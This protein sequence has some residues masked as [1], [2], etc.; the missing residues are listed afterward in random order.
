MTLKDF[1][2]V[3]KECTKAYKSGDLRKDKELEYEN[4]L[5]ETY[6]VNQEE[7]DEMILEIQADGA[8]KWWNN[9]LFEHLLDKIESGDSNALEIN[10]KFRLDELDFNECKKLLQSDEFVDAL[11]EFWQ[12]D[13]L[14]H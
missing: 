1:L 7:L 8:E 3:W 11:S 13:V 2:M 5:R 12:S 14:A 6:G 10:D 4:F 9:F